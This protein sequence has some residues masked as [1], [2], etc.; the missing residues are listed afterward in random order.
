[1]QLV[2]AS[3]LPIVDQAWLFDPNEMGIP[4]PRIEIDASIPQL[5]P[6][7]A[8]HPLPNCPA[9]AL[10]QHARGICKMRIAVSAAGAVSSIEITQSTGSGSLDQ[11]CKDAVSQSAFVPATT[12]GQ[13]VRGT[14]DV[15]IDWRLPR[16]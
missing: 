14:T 15:A 8:M 10:A 2:K 7:G 6:G 4:Q 1:M 13:P 11:A 9:D 5:P 3:G 12:A 16:P